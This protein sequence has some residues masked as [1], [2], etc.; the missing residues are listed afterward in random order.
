M[1]RRFEAKES[2]IY[3]DLIALMKKMGATSLRVERDLLGKT[4]TAQILFDRAGKRYI[5]ECSTWPDPLDNL[6]AAQLAIEYTYRIAEAYGVEMKSAKVA[7][8]I[9]AQL[10]AGREMAPDPNLLRLG[11]GR[12]WWEVLGLPNAESNAVAINN[13]FRALARVH[14]PDAGGQVADFQRLQHAYEEGLEAVR[15]GTR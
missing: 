15:N 9:Y 4:P 2:T 1:A 12:T 14:H 11:A 6:R 7:E 3:K 8:Q 10:F 13:A 5:S